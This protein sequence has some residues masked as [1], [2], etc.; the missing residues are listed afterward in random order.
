MS[1]SWTEVSLDGRLLVEAS[2]GTGK[3]WTL[4]A[5]YLRLIIEQR[6]TPHDIVVTAF[7]DAAA[8][9]L[10]QRIRDRLR[11]AVSWLQEGV[12]REPAIAAYLQDQAEP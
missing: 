9:E 3:T 1:A 11:D 7:T 4:A 8:Q 5:L 6:R 10:R 12:C 2:A